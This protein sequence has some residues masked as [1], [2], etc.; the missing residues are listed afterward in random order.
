MN[1][2]SR[3]RLEPIICYSLN[4]FSRCK[5]NE[6][7]KLVANAREHHYETDE[8]LVRA[9]NMPTDIHIILSGDA[10]LVLGNDFVIEPE[11]TEEYVVV[12]FDVPGSIRK[13]RHRIRVAQLMAKHTIGDYEILNN[14]PH[15]LDVVAGY[16]GV[17]VLSIAAS[18]FVR[19]LDT[20]GA[21]LRQRLARS[22]RASRRW[23]AQQTEKAEAAVRHA[24]ITAA[25]LATPTA[26]RAGDEGYLSGDSPGRTWSP[27]GSNRGK[28]MSSPVSA[29][30]VLSSP[31]I[32]STRAPK[33][34]MYIAPRLMRGK[35]LKPHKDLSRAAAAVP[36][37]IGMLTLPEHLAARSLSVS[38]DMMSWVDPMRGKDPDVEEQA[39]SLWQPPA[40]IVLDP[41]EVAAFKVDPY[42]LPDIKPN[43]E[44]NPTPSDRQLQRYHGG[45][46]DFIPTV[47]RLA[48]LEI[49]NDTLRKNFPM[50]RRK[51]LTA[52]EL[53]LR[54]RPR[55]DVRA[56]QE[57][58][59]NK[60]FVQ[61]ANIFL[62]HRP[63]Q[64]YSQSRAYMTRSLFGH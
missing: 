4:F 58:A 47:A 6:I 53:Q 64:L 19:F 51:Q 39:K 1:R 61:K 43:S 60:D 50:P 20:A 28:G 5:R 62:K 40:E 11:Y 12:A 56:L 57:R 42:K 7:E 2:N 24:D 32:A 29:S 8:V 13:R 27:D 41:F 48:R 63:A 14:L 34:A 26:A 52:S 46:A 59:D 30:P 31:S 25:H 37:S 55:G 49:R 16:A 54:A 35:E 23:L 10:N 17:S 38:P 18:D 36:T 21:N 44:T 22:L 15:H 9:G 45:M 3:F 33:R